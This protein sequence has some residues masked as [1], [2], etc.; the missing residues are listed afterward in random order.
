[1][2]IE[3]TLRVLILLTLV[4]SVG[5]LFLL[6]QVHLFAALAAGAVGYLAYRNLQEPRPVLP[7]VQ[8]P[9]PSDPLWA[10]PAQ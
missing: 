7:P 5:I 2:N 3:K 8:P 9:P 6:L 4:N 1:M 10:K